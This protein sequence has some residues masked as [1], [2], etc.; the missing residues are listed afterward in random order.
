MCA[1]AAGY[2]AF[3]LIACLKHLAPSPEYIRTADF[4]PAVSILK[5]VRGLHP[6]F[7]EALRTHAE[8]EYPE[9]ELIVGHGDP[10]DSAIPEIDRAIAR[11]PDKDIRR[12]LCTQAAPNG[13]VGV[14]LG[15]AQHARHPIWIV[16]DADIAVP[17]GYIEAVTR[18]LADPR[19]G[20]VTCLY[21]AQGESWPARFEALGV[22]TDF[23]P[24][25]LVAP[26][27]GV[28]EFG[29]G[30]TLAFRRA[31]LDR[32]GGFNALAEYLADDYQLGARIHQLGLRNIISRVVVQTRLHD[33]TWKAIWRHQLRWA[34]TVRLS[35]SDGYIGLP[36]TF[37]TL[38]AVLAAACGLWGMA[39][40]LMAIR[41]AM[42]LTAGWFVLGCRDVPRFLWAVPLR[43]LYGVGVWVAGLF[44][45][46]VEWG[47]ENLRLD[48]SG[49][50]IG[51]RHP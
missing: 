38:W 24:S 3:A 11:Y 18:P 5:P 1:L 47:G 34:R 19:I 10:N 17:P 25:A 15:L 36:L 22:A 23:A 46:T 32:I 20:V 43:D 28:S 29:F 41:L 39:G 50:I 49:R 2:Q 16:N 33:G 7:D 44:G 14:L 45:D 6:G 30:S 37:A 12:A 26:F 21:R 27:A 4:L 51:K 13:K 35:R 40:A 42:A 48:S 9:F 31:D 8:Q